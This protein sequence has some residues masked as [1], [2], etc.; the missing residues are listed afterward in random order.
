MKHLA[1]SFLFLS[2]LATSVG[3]RPLFPLDN[4]FAGEESSMEERVAL[5]K[6]LGFPGVVT[7]LKTFTSEWGQALRKSDLEVAATYLVLKPGKNGIVVPK[8]VASHL[9][10]FK[11]TKTQVWVTVGKVRKFEVTEA[12]ALAAIL[13]VADLARENGLKT[14]IYPHYSFFTDTNERALRLAQAAARED[15]GVAFT[16]CH[17]LRQEEPE[18]MEAT[19]EA[20]AGHLM[21]V[22]VNGADAQGKQTG[23]W[24]RLI[25]PVGQGDFELGRVL[26]QLDEMAYEGPITLQCYGLSEP[27]AAHLAA[28][29]EAWRKLTTK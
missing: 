12:E 28:S 20:A 25:L 23:D 22:Q 18:A 3:A 29:A 5:L 2:L 14:V 15:V 7:E 17:F 16:L 21:A 1:K 11:E 8:G 6:G 26:S 24:S 9:A 19:L 13:Q 10:E 4:A 27:A